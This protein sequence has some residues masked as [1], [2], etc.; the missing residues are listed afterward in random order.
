MRSTYNNRAED[1]GF[2]KT[3]NTRPPGYEQLADRVTALEDLVRA[4]GDVIDHLLRLVGPAPQ[5]A[6]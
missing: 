6:A 1:A 3:L 4:Q 2:G 5:D